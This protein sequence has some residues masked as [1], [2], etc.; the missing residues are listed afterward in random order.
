MWE[1]DLTWRCF[2]DEFCEG[3]FQ[4]VGLLGEML[5][6]SFDGSCD[7]GCAGMF[8]LFL[9]IPLLLSVWLIWAVCVVAY[10]VVLAIIWQ[11]R[12]WLS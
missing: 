3:A 6:N 7:S 5:C 12:R 1:K 10:I 4:S 8:I 11:I 9:F 2:W